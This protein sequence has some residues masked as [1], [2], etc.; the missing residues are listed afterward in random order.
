M[1]A[2]LSRLARDHKRARHGSLGGALA[3]GERARRA[4]Q[5]GGEILDLELDP[6]AL[7]PQ[8]ARIVGDLQDRIDLCARGGRVAIELP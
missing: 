1:D 5:G 7:R 2:L 8:R 6:A 4:G 3:R